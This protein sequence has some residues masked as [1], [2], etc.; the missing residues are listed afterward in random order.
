[1]LINIKVFCKVISSVIRPKD[2]SQNGGSSK[3]KRAKFFQKISISYLLIRTYTCAYQGIKKFLFF[4]K[5]CCALFSCYL[6][7]EIHP[8]ALL[9]TILSFLKGL[10]RHAQ[11]TQ[12]SMQY[13]WDISRKTLGM[14]DFLHASN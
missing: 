13:L 3:T 9:L 1:M 8:F 7:F 4:W 12:I 14:K 5:I 10:A 11:S 2:E 6:H